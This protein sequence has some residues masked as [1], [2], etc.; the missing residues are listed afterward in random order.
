MEILETL[1]IYIKTLKGRETLA[2]SQYTYAST[3][4]PCKADCGQDGEFYEGQ[5]QV[6]AEIRG[7]LTRLLEEYK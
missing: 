7:E 1:K 6:Y 2:K 5:E 4:N 3:N